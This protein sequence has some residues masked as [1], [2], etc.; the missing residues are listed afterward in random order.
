MSKRKSC[1]PSP[2]PSRKR[3]VEGSN[4][5]RE[6]AENSDENASLPSVTK[7][8]RRTMESKRAPIPLHLTMKYRGAVSRLT[9]RTHRE[10]H[11]S[12]SSISS[13]ASSVSSTSTCPPTTPA[14]DNIPSVKVEI[15]GGTL[16]PQTSERKVAPPP[17]NFSKPYGASRVS[18]PGRKPQP[19]R[20]HE[21]TLWMGKVISRG[22]DEDI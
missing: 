5:S 19:L 13:M 20:R 3:G 14:E 8:V 4:V 12:P 6:H 9:R 11:H 16:T 2:P 21:T 10:A 1:S 22:V 7:K 15:A 17:L 18:A